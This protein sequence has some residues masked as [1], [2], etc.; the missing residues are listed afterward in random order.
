MKRAILRFKLEI[1]TGIF[2]ILITLVPYWQ[3]TNHEFLNIDDEIF[4]TDNYYVKQG[5]S[6][7]GIKWAFGFT[8][9]TYWK[10]LTWLSHMADCQIYGLNPG[11]HLLT[12]LIFHIGSCLL[13]FTWLRTV[14]GSL[15][16]SG[17]VAAL[18]ALHPLNVESV[19]WISERKNVLSTFFWFLTL[20]LYTFYT[21][22]P[23]I[24]R[25]L[26]T[27]VS[28][29]LGLMAKP[30]IVT[31]PF[32]LLLLDHW[33]LGRITGGWKQIPELIKEKIPFFLLTVASLC[34]TLTNLGG[35]NVSQEHVPVHARIIE[36]AISYFNYLEKL[37]LPINLSIFYPPHFDDVSP[38]KSSMAFIGLTLFSV[39]AIKLFRKKPYIFTGWFWFAGTFLPAIG[40]IRNGLWPDLADRFTYIPFIGIF[41]IIAF[42]IPELVNRL[43]YHKV[44]LVVAASTLVS[45]CFIL[46]CV[47]AAYWKDSTTLF[48][49][50]INVTTDNYV[51][52]NNL[53]VALEEQGQHAEAKGHFLTALEIRP[54]Y[55]E[56][57]N[58]LGNILSR[59]GDLSGAEHHFSA[60]LTIYSK[61]SKAHNNIGNILLQQNK[62]GPAIS[63]YEQ[64]IKIDPY[65][66]KAHVNFGSALIQQ[67]RIDEGIEQY[68]IA[69]E[70]S[71]DFWEAHCNLASTL[72]TN[73]QSDE[74]I[75]HAQKALALKPDQPEIL[76]TLGLAFLK[77]NKLN[78]SELYF[79]KSANLKPES[80]QTLL[81]LAKVYSLKQDYDKAVSIYN[82]MIKKWPDLKNVYYN[83]ACVYSKLGDINNSIKWLTI[84]IEKGYD[85]WE[86][87]KTDPDLNSIRRSTEYKKIL[88]KQPKINGG[89]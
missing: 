28:Y 89:F 76:F 30:M 33:P 87:I 40:L 35:T 85:N 36:A 72:V 12:N 55:A 18:F 22:K 45:I 8:D 84:S 53:G 23:S 61:F 62:I 26:I 15:W 81:Y 29:A 10:P 79:K 6:Y 46:T 54:F 42:G 17:F 57:H 68:K 5:F 21:R 73:E 65:Y 64:A 47:Q 25:Y 44:F 7:E 2:L 39:L 88:K 13:L 38:W 83:L 50:A 71:P 51:A 49:H 66:A 86:L 37:I 75:I 80:P 9:I 14:T 4:V 16:K 19:A 52:H 63:H 27:L 43:K 78:E 34:I 1:M 70:I 24:R 69:I 48:S 41:L 82:P 3:I 32:V 77:K 60:A 20:L 67:Q 11:H 31:L 56:A 59:E 74:A 58:N